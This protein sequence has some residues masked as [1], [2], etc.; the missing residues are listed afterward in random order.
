[1]LQLK[2]A[3]GFAGDDLVMTSAQAEQLIEQCSQG[4]TAGC[5]IGL[6]NG[7]FVFHDMRD[8]D[9]MADLE[10]LRTQADACAISERIVRTRIYRID[11]IY[12]KQSSYKHKSFNYNKIPIVP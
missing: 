2:D 11:G 1:M 5:F 4:D 10:C 12:V 3:P 7:E 6:Q 9:R 8:F